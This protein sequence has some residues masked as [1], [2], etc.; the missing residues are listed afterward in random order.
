M[1]RAV[2]VAHFTAL[3]SQPLGRGYSG[4]AFLRLRHA[5]PTTPA[6]DVPRSRSVAG[7]GTAPT[8]PRSVG[9]LLIVFPTA[10][11]SSSKRVVNGFG[12]PDRSIIRTKAPVPS[13]SKSLLPLMSETK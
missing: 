3:D 8:G 12:M 2:K 4:R 9:G 7:S 13:Y 11:R 5:P 6:R 10:E 1:K